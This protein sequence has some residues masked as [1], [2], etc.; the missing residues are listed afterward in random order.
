MIINTCSQK[1]KE[2]EDLTFP[3]KKTIKNIFE[4]NLEFAYKKSHRN[5]FHNEGKFS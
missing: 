4:D 3:Q 1:G 5:T 2:G